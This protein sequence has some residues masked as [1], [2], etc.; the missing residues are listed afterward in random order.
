M[1]R[2]SIS[3]L[4]TWDTASLGAAG[5]TA[6]S[7]AATLDGAIDASIRSFHS[8]T[9]WHGKTHDAAESKLNAERDHAFEV[10]NVLNQ[11]ADEAGDAATDLGFAKDYVLREVDSAIAEGFDVSETGL[12]TH[13]DPSKEEQARTFEA[14]IIRGLDTVGDLDDT[15]GTRLEGLASD[16][17][18]M[19]NG[20]PD[21]DIRGVGLIDPDVLVNRLASMT[22][23][24]RAELLAGL[25]P[26]QLRRLAQADPQ[27]IGNMDG[28]PLAVRIDANEVNIRNALIDERQTHPPDENRIKQLVSMLEQFDDPF[29]NSADGNGADDSAVER[30]FLAFENTTN[31][32]M[33]ELVG[34][35][36]PTTRN[37]AVYVPGTG[38]NLN[39]SQSNHDSAWNLAHATGGPVILYMNGELPQNMFSM[40][41]DSAV[42]TTYANNMA[43]KLVAFGHELDRTLADVAPDA[44][45]TYIGHSYGGSVVGTAE[46]LGLNADRV[47]YASSAGTGVLD[48]PWQN[49]NPHVERYSLTA[50]GDPIH[51]AQ[52]QGSI[53]HG[54]DPDTAPGVTRLDTGYYGIWNEEHPD[55]LVQGPDG[56]GDY[57]NDPS[58][59]A[60]QNMVK[61]IT[62]KD[63]VPYLWRGPDSELSSPRSPSGLESIPG[64]RPN[65]IEQRGW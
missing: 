32:N 63:P 14:K 55:E 37:V 34:A 50:P 39:G 17:I 35:I 47:I 3:Q 13:P 33:I 1:T 62:G 24:Q 46:Q 65:A 29:A 30:T 40:S 57:W 27:A 5:S 2:T 25:T 20:Q 31:G 36:T 44:A 4:R 10:R 11:I 6:A 23:D 41:D 49:P 64:S 12:V 7:N 52:S 26:E 60:F 54:G 8:S 43:P 45:T 19:I 53:Q 28:V 48:G 21:I 61:V 18:S 16:L 38:T 9:T 59:D 42:D 58:S 15:Y 51:Y 56:H 22:P